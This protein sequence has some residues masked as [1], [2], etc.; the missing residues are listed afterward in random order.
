MSIVVI[1]PDVTYKDAKTN[2]RT[3]VNR[4]ISSKISEKFFDI[5]K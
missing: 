1:S 5:Y 2:Y 4:R 3:L